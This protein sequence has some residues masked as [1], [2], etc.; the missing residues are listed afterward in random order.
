[1]INIDYGDEIDRE[2]ESGKVNRIETFEIFITVH[3]ESNFGKLTSIRSTRSFN[4]QSGSSIRFG[5]T[6]IEGIID[7][8]FADCSSVRW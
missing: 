5:V 6:V 7:E 3:V 8:F 2:I 1:M 4:S